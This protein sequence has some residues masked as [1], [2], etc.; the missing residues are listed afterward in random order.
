[1]LDGLVLSGGGDV[2]PLAYGE[3][4]RPEVAGVDPNLD[5]SE[6]ALLGGKQRTEIAQGAL[7]VGGAGPQRFDA[8]LG[9]FAWARESADLL[10][11]VAEYQGEP[12]TVIVTKPAAGGPEQIWVVGAGCSA[13]RTDLLRRAT[14]SAAG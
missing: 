14:L 4:P 10:V 2:D 13:S 12:A 11:D 8:A 9:R 6:R 3:E 5:A 7:G 1:M